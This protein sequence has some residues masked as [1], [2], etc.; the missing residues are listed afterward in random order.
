MEHKYI[1]C[2]EFG[3]IIWPASFDAYHSHIGRFVANPISAGFVS[4]INERP[5]CYGRSESM[6]V[7]SLPE[8]SD[9][10][11]RQLGLS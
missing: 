11:A 2:K 9:L 1:R 5:N 10:L 7:D 4:F 6:N 8:D 3:F